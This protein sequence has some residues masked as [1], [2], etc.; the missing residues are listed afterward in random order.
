MIKELCAW[1]DRASVTSINLQPEAGTVLFL[2]VVC[3][4]ASL[5][6]T[7]KKGALF[8]GAELWGWMVSGE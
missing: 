2:P 7:T 6:G 3:C 8:V 4:L 1:P 5:R